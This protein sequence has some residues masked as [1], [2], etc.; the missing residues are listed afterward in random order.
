MIKLD[1]IECLIVVILSFDMLFDCL[2]IWS[3]L[4][5]VHFGSCIMLGIMLALSV[6]I[7]IACIKHVYEI[8]KIITNGDEEK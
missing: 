6:R 7:I 2:E 4:G 1:L 5:N 3:Q 8:I